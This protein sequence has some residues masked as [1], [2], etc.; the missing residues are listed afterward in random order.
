MHGGR[1]WV[2]TAVGAGSEFRFTIPVAAADAR[3]Q[4][5]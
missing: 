5:A 2:D 1:I 3:E 4:P